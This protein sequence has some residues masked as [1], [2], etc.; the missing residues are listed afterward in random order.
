MVSSI[1]KTVNK[2]LTNKCVLYVVT[3]FA[4]INLLA[5][6]SI[7]NFTSVIFF[8][9]VAYLTQYFSKNMIVILLIAMISTSILFNIQNGRTQTREGLENPDEDED[10][11]EDA[12][13]NKTAKIKALENMNTSDDEPT[14]DP[15]INQSNTAK[16]GYESIQDMIGEA[17]VKNLGKDTD[18]LMNRQKQLQESME[19]LKPM[20][21]TA[22]SMLA[23]L[24]I[25][26]MEKLSGILGKFGGFGNK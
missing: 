22:N 26:T 10:A 8:I 24:D 16:A 23:N 1:G 2:A 14:S 17:G 25:N 4:V 5:Y 12:N 19:A 3:F 7:P 15:S 6:L 18:D 13:K 20:M 21:L 9:L 11:D